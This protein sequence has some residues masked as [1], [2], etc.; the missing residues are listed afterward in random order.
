MNLTWR[1]IDDI[2]QTQSATPPNKLDSVNYFDVAG[3]WDVTD[4]ASLRL[5]VN[6]LF[7]E[8]PEYVS[9]GVT[10]RENGNTYPGL[11]DALGMY[12]FAGFTVQ[13]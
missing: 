2:E 9:Q 5:G 8:E 3:T 7:D 4:W 12:W 10:A 6:N 11:Y 13:F 1:Y